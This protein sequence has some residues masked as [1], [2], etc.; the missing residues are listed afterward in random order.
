MTAF[1]TTTTTVISATFTTTAT[2]MKESRG[3]KQKRDGLADDEFE[4]RPVERARW[5]GRGQI[6][7]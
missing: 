4:G 6:D 1:T 2:V 7:N 5:T 3:I